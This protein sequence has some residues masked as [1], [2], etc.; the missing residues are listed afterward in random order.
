[1]IVNKNKIIVEGYC[2]IIKGFK[3]F[4]NSKNYDWIYLPAR[5]KY[6]IELENFIVELYVDN[7]LEFSAE[8]KTDAYM[9]CGDFIEL[10]NQLIKNDFIV[11]E[12]I[13]E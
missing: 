11:E 2:N 5:D 7:S 10:I 1:M 8:I 6:Q 4:L 9:Y 12:Q 3:E 13:N